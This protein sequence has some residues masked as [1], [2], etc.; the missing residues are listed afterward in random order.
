[1]EKFIRARE[2]LYAYLYDKFLADDGPY[3]GGKEFEAF[4]KTSRFME[5][6]VLFAKD[7]GHIKSNRFGGVRLTGTGILYA[8]KEYSEANHGD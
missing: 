6:A 1:M 7:M 3:C 8:E 5:R 2:E 4:C